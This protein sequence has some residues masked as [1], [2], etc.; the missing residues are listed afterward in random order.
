MA[1]TFQVS[2]VEPATNRLD[3]LPERISP[4]FLDGPAEAWGSSAGRFM[5]AHN[6]FLSAVHIAYDEHH[7]LVL[8]PDAVWLC[9]AKGFAQ[10][11]KAK[12]ERLRGKFVRHEGRVNIVIECHD[13]VKG[14]PGNRWPDV[15]GRFSDA[16]AEHIG[17]QRDLVVCAFSTTGPIERA[18]SEIVLLDAMQH[19]FSYECMTLCGIPEITL[20]GTVE[21]WLQIRRRV[22]AL[23]EYDLSWW[24]SALD[25]VLDQIALVAAGKAPDLDF[26]RSMFKLSDE[27]GGPYVS[28][29]INVLFPYVVD[30]PEAGTLKQNWATTQWRKALNARVSFGGGP[31]EDSIPAGL[32]AVPFKWNYL[33]TSFE[34]EFLGGFVGVAEDEGSLAVRPAIGWAVRDAKSAGP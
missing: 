31:T 17:R 2:D 24:S 16:I 6:G 29:W 11:V 3:L 23:E 5:S 10:H 25:P 30:D 26:W 32:A 20:E 9:I 14:S 7:P 27:S 33:G 28:G 12:A 8:T 13:F 18:A 22:Q 34:M 19:Y 15:F 21:D 4:T 1:V